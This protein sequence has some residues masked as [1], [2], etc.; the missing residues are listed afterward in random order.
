MMKKNNIKEAKSEGGRKK[1]KKRRKEKNIVN[2]Q[3]VL[4]LKKKGR[5]ANVKRMK[6]NEN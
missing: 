5:K 3:D 6:I 4:K 2:K 1:E